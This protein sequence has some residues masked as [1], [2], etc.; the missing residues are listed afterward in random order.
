MVLRTG[1]IYITVVLYTVHDPPPVGQVRLGQN[2]CKPKYS[3]IKQVMQ[4][5][6]KNKILN[7]FD[8]ATQKN[9]S[10]N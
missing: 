5:P 3:C 9:C 8:D 10:L 6:V 7:S 2:Y 4:R 1:Q